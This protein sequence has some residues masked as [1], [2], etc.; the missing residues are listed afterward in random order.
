MAW[1]NF[2]NGELGLETPNGS[3]YLVTGSDKATTWGLAAVSHGSSS[4]S[5]ALRFAAAMVEAN[6]SYSFSWEKRCDA[7]VRTGPDIGEGVESLKDQSVF[8]RGFKIMIR[9]GAMAKW[10]GAVKVTST[11]DSERGGFR[12]S[13]KSTSFP[14]VPNAKRPMTSSD[15]PDASGGHQLA[16]NS[17]IDPES[18]D[19]SNDADGGVRALI[20]R[21]SFS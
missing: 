20:L 12:F 3:L 11:Q 5:V 7:T 4:N 2:V 17:F 14:G 15:R 8:I 19:E 1:Y 10:K 6:A 16:S 21:P 18:D 9:E 13:G